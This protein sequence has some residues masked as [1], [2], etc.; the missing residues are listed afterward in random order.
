MAQRAKARINV[1]LC[2]GGLSNHDLLINQQGQ[3]MGGINLD[4]S[5]HI[6]IKTIEGY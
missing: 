1:R 5:V 3:V 2:H 6:L 4:L